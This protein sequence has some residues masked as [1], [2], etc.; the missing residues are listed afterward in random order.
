MKH[1]KIAIH[2][3]CA[4]ALAALFPACNTTGS[5][6]GSTTATSASAS[7]TV[8]WLSQSGFKPYSAKTAA[9]KAHIQSLPAD[10]VTKVNRGGTNMWVYPDSANNQ[11]YV[12]NSA[13]YNAFRALRKSRSGLDS[14]EDL[15]TTFDA[16]GG[17][18]VEIYDGFVPMNA[19]D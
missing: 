4:A 9:Q 11:V 16:R 10:K 6:S 18:P 1:T 8:A 7:Q 14:E 17:T 19:L 13:Q 15:V 5:N 2:L 3:V 12:G